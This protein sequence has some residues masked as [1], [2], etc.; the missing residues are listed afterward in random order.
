MSD[1]ATRYGRWAV[2]AGASE[3]LGSAFAEAVAQGGLDVV[4]I[5]R[6][7]AVLDEVADGIRSRTGAEVRTLAVDLA[8]EDAA[9]TVIEATADLEVGLL[10]YNA[11]ADPNYQP[12]LDNPAEVALAMVHRNCTVPTRLC[13]HYAGLMVDRRRGGII[14]VSSGGGIAGA[15]NM[16]AYGATKAFDIVFAEALW[17]ELHERGV[18]VL[19]LVLGETDTPA[20]RRLRA[21]R[22]KVDDPDAPLPGVAT[23]DEVVAE[24]IEHLP[25]GPSWIV[26]EHIREGLKMLAGFSRNEVVGFM[27][28]ASKEAMG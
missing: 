24:A 14:V 4:L 26:G 22:G 5:A 12:F 25:L 2:V 23:V 15:P 7:Q 9:E 10:M 18:D 17:T 6:R 3:G 19:S 16:V 1:F 8:T 27:V 13:H 28:E 11:G 21:Q 20:L